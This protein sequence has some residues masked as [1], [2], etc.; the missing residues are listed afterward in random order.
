MSSALSSPHRIASSLRSYGAKAAWAGGFL[1][2]PVLLLRG[3]VGVHRVP[4]LPLESLFSTLFAGAQ[5]ERWLLGTASIGQ[6]DLVHGGLPYWPAQPSHAGALS[7][8]N[9][10]LDEPIAYA[11]VLA[12]ALWLTGLGPALLARR[13]WGDGRLAACTVAGLAVQLSPPVLRSVWDAELVILAVGPVA[14]ALAARTRWSCALWA[15]LAGGMGWVAAVLC[16]LGAGILRKPWAGLAALP[17]VLAV[18]VPSAALPGATRALPTPSTASSYVTMDRAVLPTGILASTPQLPA[19]PNDSGWLGL[20]ARVHGGPVAV[21]GCLLALCWKRTRIWGSLGVV[22]LVLLHAGLG[23]LPLPGELATEPAGWWTSVKHGLP[24][25]S[26][27]GGLLI[28]VVLAAGLGLGAVVRWR[29]EA[30]VLVLALCLWTS[31]LLPID[32]GVPVTNL[33]PLPAASALSSAGAG[34]V[35]ILPAWSYGQRGA[36]FA[37]QLHLAARLGRPAALGSGEWAAPAFMAHT[38]WLLDVPVHQDAATALWDHRHEAPLD[39]ARSAGFAGLLVDAWAYSPE[40]LSLLRAELHRWV[41][42]PVAE[43][44]RWLAWAL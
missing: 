3:A 23:P 29:R 26:A 8:L 13:L 36:G 27:A 19:E 20:P 7:L 9:L 34:P 31:P 16:G 6:A 22:A 42:P 18:V 5:L 21:L 12:I 40:Q 32:A 24:G 2:V 38:A 41:G 39:V 28:P 30:S 44:E 43:G 1:V 4:G 11:V 10:A 33:P 14:L 15:L 35:L 25:A 17:L 37:E